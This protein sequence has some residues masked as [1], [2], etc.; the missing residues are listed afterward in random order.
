MDLTDI[1]PLVEKPA[2]YVGNEFGAV[3]KDHARTPVR[4]AFAFPDV[5]EVGM[6]HLGGHIL[7]A[8]INSRDD[9]LCERVFAP[10]IDMEAQLRKLGQPLFA[11]ESG[12]PLRAFSIL[13]F[14]LQYEMS[15]TNLLNMLDLAQCSLFSEAR[16]EDEPIVIAGG[17]GAYNPEPLAPFIDAFVLGEGEEVIHELISAYRQWDV[18]GRRGGRQGCL[19]GLAAVPGVYVPAFYRVDYAA[20]GTVAA[21][22]PAHPG[23]PARV[24]KRVIADLSTS[25]LPQHPIV[26]YL[27]VV[28]DRALVE[29]LRGCTHGCRFCQAGMVYRPVRERPA[30]QIEQLADQMLRR[31]GCDELGLT[32]L[33]TTDH[34]MAGELVPRLAEAHGS[35]GVSV[36]LPSL[37]VDAFSV[38]LAQAVQRVR[39]TGLTFAPEAG[40]QR[41]RDVI[42]KNV[43]D[44]DLLTTLDE[45]FRA[46][47]KAVKLYFMIGLPTETDAD[48]QAIGDTAARVEEVFRRHA[49]GRPRLTISLA[50]FV[51]KPHTPFQ[52][53]GQ[54]PLAELARRQVAVRR[55]LPGRHVILDWHDARLS[56]LEAVVAR[57]DR[58]VGQ[59]LH[60]AWAK[61]CRFDG[62]R[63]RFR[64]GLWDEAFAESGLDPGFYANRQRGEAEVFPWDHLDPGVA[65][66]FLWEEWKRSQRGE[67]S[68]DCRH[69]RCTGCGVCPSLSVGLVTG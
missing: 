27:E 67:T 6:S 35:R 48:L 4:I 32:S 2:R 57:G 34:S 45:A 9:S 18:Q 54:D 20:D 64:P 16:A 21:V 47:W 38:G 55:S 39:K 23:A 58:R 15:Y 31:T 33:S 66:A 40:T 49:K 59:A 5:Y 65:K 68:P 11:L 51:P 69:G 53:F 25:V 12:L 30:G 10:W 46:G 24:R 36:S 7:Y 17:P 44:T 28:H 26:P 8:A 62:W 43:S 22:E 61:G 56:L 1:L 50:A 42:N 14:T 63:E 19:E 60:R 29:V 41:L 3:R 37:R 13:A 52:W